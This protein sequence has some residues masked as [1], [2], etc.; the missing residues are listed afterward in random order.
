VYF[1]I[2][3]WLF[4]S[5]V[6]AELYDI[7]GLPP[8]LCSII[9]IHKINSVF[10]MNFPSPDCGWT[11]VPYVNLENLTNWHEWQCEYVMQCE[12]HCIYRTPPQESL[13]LEGPFKKRKSF[14]RKTANFGQY[15]HFFRKTQNFLLQSVLAQ[16]LTYIGLNSPSPLP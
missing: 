7:N 16:I 12:Y 2:D 10:N 14:F 6:S 3:F 11:R 4:H 15:W 13:T 5:E 9:W 1:L 8:K